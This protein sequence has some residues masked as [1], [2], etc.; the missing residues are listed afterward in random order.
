MGLNLQ[1]M[2]SPTIELD[3]TTKAVVKIFGNGHLNRLN[4]YLTILLKF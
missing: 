2:W 4:I 3:L 1:L